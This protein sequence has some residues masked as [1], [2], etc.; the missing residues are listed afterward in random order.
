MNKLKAGFIGFIPFTAKG[1]DYYA[2]LEEYGKLGYKGFEH[3]G[4]LLQGDYQANLARVRAFGMEPLCMGLMAMPG[5]PEPNVDE[6]IENA[7]KLGVT[8]L[9][10]YMSL[11]A[12][13]RFGWNKEPPTY[14]EIMKQIEQFQATAAKA[15]A[16]GMKF[17]FHNHDAEFQMDFGGKTP[18]DL[19][20]ENAPDLTFEL[21]V[22]WV[23]FAGLDPVNLIY[24]LGD[25]IAALH[26]K[27]FV[28]GKVVDHGIDKPMFTT[29]GTGILNLSGVLEAG[30]QIGQEWA[31]VEQDYQ[32]NLSE[33]ETLAA[34]YLN[35]KE[36]GFLE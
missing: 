32:R 33:K 12:N 8:R 4:A 34:A 6:I 16:N 2:I 23:T 29:P 22:G 28:P 27:D 25:R 10:T 13:Y 35:M 9:V 1:E 30:V 5:M 24:K 17:M 14:D 18:F 31:I 15:K 11:A 7:K 20:V 19:M 36:T 3:S 26:I 21:D